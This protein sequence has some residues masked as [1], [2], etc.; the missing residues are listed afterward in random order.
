MWNITNFPFPP[1]KKWRRRIYKTGNRLFTNTA[2]SEGRRSKSK[3]DQDGDQKAA[4]ES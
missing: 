4:V 2:D 3:R 1:H